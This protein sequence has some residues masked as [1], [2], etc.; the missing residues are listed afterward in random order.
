MKNFITKTLITLFVTVLSIGSLKAQVDLS[1]LA[2]KIWTVV[3]PPQIHGGSTDKYEI[4]FFPTTTTTGTVQLVF[5][6]SWDGGNTYPTTPTSDRTYNITSNSGAIIRITDANWA[7]DNKRGFRYIGTTL[8][9]TPD[10]EATSVSWFTCTSVDHTDFAVSVTGVTTTKPRFQAGETVTLTM[11]LVGQ[12]F[13]GWTLTGI[14]ETD[15]IT[16]ALHQTYTFEMPANDVTI[17]AAIQ[18]IP[19]TDPPTPNLTYEQFPRFSSNPIG[20]RVSKPSSMALPTN[21]VVP[22]YYTNNT[23]QGSLPGRRLPVV[24]VGDFSSSTAMVTLSLPESVQFMQTANS[25]EEPDYV[26]F[27]ACTNLT[28]I[29][30]RGNNPYLTVENGILYTKNFDTLLLY[31]PALGGTTLTVR[32]GTEYIKG[33]AFQNNL[34]LVEV[35]VPASVKGMGIWSF[36]GAGSLKKITFSALETFGGFDFDGGI[37]NLEVHFLSETP[38]W[39]SIPQYPSCHIT[40]TFGTGMTIKNIFVPSRS[41][42]EAYKEKWYSLCQVVHTEVLDKIK[43]EGALAVTATGAKVEWNDYVAGE[44]VKLTLIVPVGMEFDYWTA[45]GIDPSIISKVNDTIY[46]FVMPANVVS[47][48]AVYKHIIGSQL[49]TNLSGGQHKFTGTL[50]L[51]GTYSYEGTISFHDISGVATILFETWMGASGRTPIVNGLFVPDV[52]EYQFTITSGGNKLFFSYYDKLSFDSIIWGGYPASMMPQASVFTGTAKTYTVTTLGATADRGKYGL[53]NSSETVTLTLNPPANMKFKQWDRVIGINAS[54]IS[55]VTAGET[56][57]FT[58]PSNNV[59]LTVVWEEISASFAVNVTGATAAL[60]STEIPGRFL[61]GET[62]TLT[63]NVPIA[64][65]FDNWTAQG[66]Q[67]SAITKVDDVTYTFTMPANNVTLT[68]NYKDIP[69]DVTNPTAGLVYSPWPNSANPTGWIVHGLLLQGA[70]SPAEVIIPTYYTYPAGGGMAW[71][72]GVRLPVVGIEGFSTSN[73]IDMSPLVTISIPETVENIGGWDNFM[74]EDIVGFY[75]ATSLQ[76]IILRGDNPHFALDN[77]V[78]YSKDFKTLVLHP[79]GHTGSYTVKDG[80]THIKGGAFHSG[81][82]TEITLPNSVIEVGTGAF[83]GCPNLRRIYFGT[84]LETLK[85]VLFRNTE[86]LQLYFTAATPPTTITCSPYNGAGG[87]F[88]GSSIIESQLDGK[89]CITA[90]YVPQGTVDTYVDAFMCS[91]GRTGWWRSLIPLI[92]VAGAYPVSVTG[93]TS[94]LPEYAP[95]DL[96]TLTLITG[97]EFIGWINVVGIPES[98]II[99]VN[100][101]TYTFVMPT[102]AVSLTADYVEESFYTVTIT[103]PTNGT[104]EVKNGSTT[105]NTGVS[106]VEGTVLTLTAIPAEGYQ[107]VKWTHDN[108]IHANHTHT[109]IGHVTIS[110]EF[111]K[112]DV[113][114]RETIENKLS[115]Y[116]NPVQ[117]EFVVSGYEV[118]GTRTLHI[119][120]LD[121]NGKRV[122]V[123]HLAPNT[124]HPVTVNISHLPNG[125]YIVKIGNNSVRIVKQ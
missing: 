39:A 2:N 7:S 106:L 96:V 121:M 122:H 74:E 78:V 43:I 100:D 3:V 32:D 69:D 115:V 58:M 119:E 113:S 48:T 19:E 102:N 99:K 25:A 49:L 118:R 109:L 13:N 64:R 86:N 123:K 103:P 60:G 105:V 17:V 76:N 22:N 54:A 4:R 26:G 120:V 71:L 87:T 6:Q 73:Q 63:L 88:A 15:L 28:T 81:K 11:N 94:D 62:V 66:I 80:T 9:Y 70:P 90:I 95:G 51:S 125:V 30:L 16:V 77:G 117:T 29:I 75:G 65:E 116:P 59:A 14:T 104:I 57:S 27:Y 93:A 37:T 83:Q 101:L 68:A 112:I 36:R 91:L 38:P 10:V 18:D 56:Y 34:T 8:Q 41:A 108:H 20:W 24:A 46:T 45:A 97:K 53:Y 44:T 33:A 31:P 82:L 111:E 67:V 98:A 114:I 85:T 52:S 89:T 72:V 35:V 61:P 40:G 84:G 92:K 50:N 23:G 110:A 124:S 55:T 47:V 42:M 79:R 12:T 1:N 5:Y 107:F 21:V